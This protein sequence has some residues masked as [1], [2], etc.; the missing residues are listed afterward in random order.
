VAREALFQLFSAAQPYAELP[1][2]RFE[3]VLRMLAEGY[4]S[5]H[6]QRARTCTATVSTTCCADAVARG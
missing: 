5:R 2:E 1:R 6:G 4:A 3:A